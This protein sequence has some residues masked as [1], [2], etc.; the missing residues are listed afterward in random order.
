MLTLLLHTI[1]RH[2]TF[3]DFITKSACWR[4]LRTEN[5][6]L[7]SMSTTTSP[8]F[9]HT[10]PSFVDSRFQITRPRVFKSK[11]KVVSL[12]ITLSH[13]PMVQLIFISL[14]CNEASDG[15]LQDAASRLDMF[16]IPSTK[17]LGCSC[18]MRSSSLL[19]QQCVK[20]ITT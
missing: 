19:Q 2:R 13:Y 12:I 5:N 4:F 16:I 11:K 6:G 9:A 1:S 20:I 17:Q 15:A 10:C 7:I 18:T 14:T 3:A 8:N